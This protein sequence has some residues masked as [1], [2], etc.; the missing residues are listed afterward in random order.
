MNSL[1]MKYKT[2]TII[3]VIISIGNGKY[4]IQIPCPL[5]SFDFDVRFCYKLQEYGLSHHEWNVQTFNETFYLKMIKFFTVLVCSNSLTKKINQTLK[6]HVSCCESRMFQ[7]KISQ[8]SRYIHIIQCPIDSRP[9][10][11]L[12]LQINCRC[13]W[14]QVNGAINKMI[15]S[16]TLIEG[17]V[18][19]CQLNL[20]N[21]V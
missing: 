10:F 6:L 19:S 15:F 2:K 16:R 11:T 12:L 9:I 8:K 21:T 5:I 17:T 7:T 3:A 20:P 13:W 4:I 14:S 18:I 1:V